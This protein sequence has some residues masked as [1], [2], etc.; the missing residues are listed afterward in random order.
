MFCLFSD[1]VSVFFGC[2]VCVCVCVSCLVVCFVVY[3][4][5]VLLFGCIC[6][7]LIVCLL[8]WLFVC[9]FIYFCNGY[10]SGNGSLRTLTFWLNWI[11]RNGTT[12]ARNA[13]CKGVNSNQVVV[14]VFPPVNW[15]GYPSLPVPRSGFSEK[16]WVP[17]F[18]LIG[19]FPFTFYKSHGLKSQT[20][21]PNHQLRFA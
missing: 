5:F 15:R 12:Q 13:F 19:G 9:F 4:V 3:F 16:N 20:N 7:L 8:S 17:L 10:L 21:N 2:C 18:S 14:L 1:W 6:F 11:C